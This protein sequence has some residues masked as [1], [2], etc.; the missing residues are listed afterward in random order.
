MFSINVCVVGDSMHLSADSHILSIE[1]T[2]RML[3]DF[4][5]NSLQHEIIC[6][7]L[8][9]RVIGLFRK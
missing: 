5:I 4:T 6:N 8:V 1:K 3:L 9:S 7:W 2:L